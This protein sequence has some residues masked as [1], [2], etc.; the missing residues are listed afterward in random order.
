[1]T[2]SARLQAVRRA[3]NRLLFQAEFGLD[4]VDYDDAPLFG[5]G[6]VDQDFRDHT[7]TSGL[8]RADFALSPDTAIFGRVRA[9]LR[10]YDLAP[11]AVPEIRDSE[12]LTIDGGAD[13]DISNLAR[14]VVGIGYTQQKYDS[15]ALEDVNGLSIDG[16]VEWFPTQ[17]TTVTFTASRAVK[18]APFANSGGFFGA[19]IGMN[20]DHELRRNVVVSAGFTLA[21]DDYQDIARA[22]ERFSVMAG[23]T[24]FMNRNVGIRASWI[25]TDQDS[26]GAAANQTFERNLLGISLALRP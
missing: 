9:N 5:G 16:L 1:M 19:S 7:Q 8:V 14:G 25:Y 11:P 2:R 15:S 24:Y 18:D 26:S 4:E 17:L 12:G 22:D 21:E 20:V 10:D 3:A 6:V 23:L 13:F